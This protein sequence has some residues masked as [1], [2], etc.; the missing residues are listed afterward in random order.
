MVF[1]NEFFLNYARMHLLISFWVWFCQF[2][3][4]QNHSGVREGLSRLSGSV[5]MAVGNFIMCEDLAYKC[6][7]PFFGLGGK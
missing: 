2:D 4:I 5:D 6:V 7:A 3:T 1:K